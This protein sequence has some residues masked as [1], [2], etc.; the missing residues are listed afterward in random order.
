MAESHPDYGVAEDFQDS[1]SRVL[2][3]IQRSVERVN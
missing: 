1:A 2:S 3:R